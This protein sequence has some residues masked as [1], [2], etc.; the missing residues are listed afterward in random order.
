M[1]RHAVYA[2]CLSFGLALGGG[3]PAYAESADTETEAVE[4]YVL[5]PGDVVDISVLEDSSLNRQVLVRPDG[6]ISLPLA[7]TVVAAERTP[8][9]L[10]VAIRDRLAKDFIEPPTVTVSLINSVTPPEEQDLNLIYVIGQVPNPGRFEIQ[11][12]VDILQALAIAG[13]PGVFA[14]TT[15]I[16]LRKR[17]ENGGE[18]V[19]LFD[20]D[21]VQEGNGI[22]LLVVDDGDIVVV[23]E[24]GLFE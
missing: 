12:P 14:A 4:D 18:T 6:K 16:Q 20:Y 3:L 15:R 22:Q 24:R 1:L 10:Q 23:P 9:A 19:T 8:E 2:V 13:G 17:D 5:Q 21:A 7:G 11:D